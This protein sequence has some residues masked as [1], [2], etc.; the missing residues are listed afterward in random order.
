ML[1][2]D[3]LNLVPVPIERQDAKSQLDLTERRRR[4]ADEIYNVDFHVVVSRASNETM[5]EETR[6]LNK[7]E[8]KRRLQHL[9]ETNLRNDTCVKDTLDFYFRGDMPLLM[10]CQHLSSK[11]NSPSP[12]PR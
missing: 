3:A 5:S 12:S 1:L 6:D 4:D 11:C 8:L 10:C 2:S 9:S 7:K